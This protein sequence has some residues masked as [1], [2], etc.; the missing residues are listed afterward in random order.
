MSAFA[1]GIVWGLLPEKA[2]WALGLCLAVFAIGALWNLGSMARR[3]AGWWGVAALA[4]ALLAIGGAVAGA[5]RRRPA[6]EAHEQVPE[7]HQDGLMPPMGRPAPRGRL[8]RTAKRAAKPGIFGI[9]R[10]RKAPRGPAR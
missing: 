6:S 2:W 7:G 4:G 5:F 10:M 9:P 8:R 3:L 1:L